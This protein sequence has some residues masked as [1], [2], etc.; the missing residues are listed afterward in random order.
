MKNM[1]KKRKKQL[2]TTKKQKDK[3]N[4]KSWRTLLLE[5]VL[6]QPEH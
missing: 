5:G 2:K 4:A 6:I 1:N 3:N